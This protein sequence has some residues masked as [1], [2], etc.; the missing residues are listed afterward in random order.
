[1]YQPNTVN[2]KCYTVINSAACPKLQLR[3]ECSAQSES[4]AS[5]RHAIDQYCYW[6]DDRQQEQAVKCS[7][8]SCL[9]LLSV[10]RVDHERHRKIG[11]DYLSGF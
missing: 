2:E 9:I 7:F 6:L 5:N 11:P 10:R 3:G 4:Q 1:M 8:G